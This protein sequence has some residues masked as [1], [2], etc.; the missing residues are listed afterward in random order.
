MYIFIFIYLQGMVYSTT[1]MVVIVDTI[2]YCE[3]LDCV[4]PKWLPSNEFRDHS[5]FSANGTILH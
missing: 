2:M 4:A 1:F 3:G 5:E